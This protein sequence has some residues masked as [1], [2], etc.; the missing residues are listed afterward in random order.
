[1]ALACLAACASPESSQTMRGGISPDSRYTT[2]SPATPL[3]NPGNPA[4][5]GESAWASEAA[6]WAGVPYQK[7][8]RN[9]A[10]MDASGLVSRMYENVARV[11]V[12]RDLAEL[13]RT[14]TA[15][16]RG[17]TRPGDI[18]MFQMSEQ[19]AIWHAGVL[20]GGGRFIHATIGAG[21]AYS[22]L[23]EPYWAERF[24]GGRRIAR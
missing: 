4:I 14:G 2:P 12:P 6:K 23:S 7:G 20:L 3:P 13:G 8:G 22:D 21:V 18:V 5:L 17:Q 19:P 24:R 15:I 9:R 1:M 11:E 16:P 10:G